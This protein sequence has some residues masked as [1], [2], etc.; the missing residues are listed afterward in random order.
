[1]AQVEHVAVTSRSAAQ[2]AERLGPQRVPRGKARRRVQV[3]LDGSIGSDPI[4][5]RVERHAPIHAD[6]IAPGLG[7]QPQQLAGPHT[8][9][10]RRG[11][12][13]AQAGEETV[14]GGEHEPLVVIRIERPRPAVEHL[15]GLGPR[16]DLCPQMRER[17][18]RETLGQARP[19]RRVLVHQRLRPR[20]VARRAALHQVTREGEGTPR[21]ADQWN[22]QLLSKQPDGLE[23]VRLVRL[24]LERP[25]PVEVARGPDGLLDDRARPRL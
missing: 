11:L 23:D 20:M 9:M 14:C 25:E 4:P 7:H 8:E 21:E 17:E 19:Q 2:H 1:M 16:F 18:V 6:H 22:R 3:A 15:E 12:E 24:G 5:R 13:V 10:D